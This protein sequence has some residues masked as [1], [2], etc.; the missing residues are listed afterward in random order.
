MKCPEQGVSKLSCYRR[1][2]GG[3]IRPLRHGGEEVGVY[4][5]L[6]KVRAHE[7]LVPGAVEGDTRT[8][9]RTHTAWQETPAP[10]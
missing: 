6:A 10:G 3:T 7:S 8:G 5:T 2:I 9:T 1:K 4:V